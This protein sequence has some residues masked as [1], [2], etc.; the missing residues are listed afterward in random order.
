MMEKLAKAGEGE[1]GG[2]RPP[3]FTVSIIT[4]KVV[5]YAPVER[6]DTLLLYIL[7]DNSAACAYR[8]TI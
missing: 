3:P 8:H 6:A 4:Y 1:G 7:F 2:A 5:V